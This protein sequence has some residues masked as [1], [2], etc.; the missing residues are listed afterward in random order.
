MTPPDL[1]SLLE[2]WE[3]SLRAVRKSPE[4]IRSYIGAV[5]RFL[6]WCEE[7]E[8]QP[9][10]ERRTVQTFIAGRLELGREAGTV[11]TELRGLRLFSAWLV[12]EDELDRDDLL[13]LKSA[14]VD[15]KVVD[16]LTEDDCRRLIEVC[17]GKTFRDR[18]DEAIVRLLIESPCRSGDIV[19]MMKSDVDLPH[20]VVT[21]RR[22]K[23]GKGRIIAFGPQTARALDR[24]LRMRRSHT[25]A[26]TPNMW[27][28]DRG[29]TFAYGGLAATLKWRAKLAGIEGFY[30]HLTRHTAAQRWLAAGGSEGGLMAIAGWSSR[31]M[32]DRY[33]RSTAADRAVTEARKLHLGEL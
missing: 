12:E 30:P 6:A 8:R 24:Y 21:I 33:T 13:T 15:E 18:R 14:K 25:L 10:L 11:R 29:R 4:T 26:D 2:S 1:P 27:L 19:G 28:G 16:R 7:E 20:G 32:L 22:G 3:I 23:G 9:A 17:A 5:K 31:Q